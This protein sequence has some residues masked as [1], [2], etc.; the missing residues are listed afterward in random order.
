MYSSL[1]RQE[2]KSRI[3]TENTLSC[4]SCLLSYDF[5][6]YPSFENLRAHLRVREAEKCWQTCN[7]RYTHDTGAQ[8]VIILTILK[9]VIEYAQR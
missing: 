1:P 7:E 5:L 4:R 3:V 8:R 9:N 6:V 2:K